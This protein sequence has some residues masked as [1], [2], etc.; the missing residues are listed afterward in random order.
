[1]TSLMG[2]LLGASPHRRH[3]LARR[4]A[5]DG[6]PDSGH[7]VTSLYRRIT[8][9]LFLHSFL[10]RLPVEQIMVLEQVIGE[11]AGKLPTLQL[12]RRL[13]LDE[14]RVHG[15]VAA[16]AEA[17]LIIIEGRASS[18]AMP[19]DLLALLRRLIR[20][21]RDRNRVDGAALSREGRSLSMSG[22]RSDARTVRQAPRLIAV[23]EPESLMLAGD[24]LLEDIERLLDGAAAGSVKLPP[25]V[26]GRRLTIPTQLRQGL[27][28]PRGDWRA[29]TRIGYAL[30]CAA[31][32]GLLVPAA[33][34]S[35]WA[36]VAG[37]LGWRHLDRERQARAVYELWL[38]DREW[39]EPLARP[40]VIRRREPPLRFDRVRQR[41]RLWLADAQP[42]V[43]YSLRSLLD[44][45]RWAQH[46]ALASRQDTGTLAPSTSAAGAVAA[47]LA[48]GFHWLG[49]VDIGRDAQGRLRAFRLTARGA[50]LVRQ[51]VAT[52]ASRRGFARVGY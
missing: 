22:P 38:S 3:E 24:L 39:Q 7:L 17:G 44:R 21:R 47:V 15:A 49:G 27:G 10:E 32:L 4:W 30:R 33:G 28:A 14:Q 29:A 26:K 46:P 2:L 6:D 9:A 42:G 43:W 11:P 50:Q 45:V 36:P 51:P 34:E 18:L 12:L 52:D 1:M 40:R 25:R 35:G 13:P 41:L 19:D 48:V 31:S 20:E 16:L 37:N 23:G 5:V 8:D